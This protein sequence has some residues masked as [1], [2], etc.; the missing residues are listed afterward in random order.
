[1]LATDD[2]VSCITVDECLIPP[3]WL[4]PMHI[5]NILGPG[6]RLLKPGICCYLK[7]PQICSLTALANAEYLCDAAAAPGEVMHVFGLHAKI[8]C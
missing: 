1:M 4:I 5:G 8:D 6:L 7:G 3:A 2:A